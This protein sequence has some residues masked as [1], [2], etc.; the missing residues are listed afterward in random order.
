LSCTKEDKF[1]IPCK[2]DN[3]ARVV[4]LG[5]ALYGA[6]K[7]EDRVLVM[8]LGTGLGIGFVAA[9]KLNEPQPYAHMAG[10]ISITD[11]ETD[12]Y[13]GRDGCLESLV[14]G[15]GLCV[16]AEKL[17]W[18]TKYNEIPLN[19]ENIFKERTTN[20][21]AGQLVNNLI[22]HLKTGIDNYVNIYAPN[23]IILGGG[24]AKGLK[25]DLDKLYNPGL[26][27]PYKKYKARLTISVLE[28]EAGILGSAA[29]FNS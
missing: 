16:A 25:N 13:C 2:L 7:N 26:L 23:V 24:L 15:T 3:D 27:G 21:D 22:G 18:E 5:E 9:G 19:A 11:A 10:H 8:T 20:N 29:L 6:G 4:A 1:K 17:L 14:S 12:C 28:E